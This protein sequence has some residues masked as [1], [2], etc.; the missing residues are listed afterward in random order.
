MTYAATT[1]PLPNRYLIILC[2]YRHHRSDHFVWIYTMTCPA[3]KTMVIFTGLC[4]DAVTRISLRWTRISTTSPPQE[5]QIHTMKCLEACHNSF[6]ATTEVSIASNQG[7][8]IYT[9]FRWHQYR[10]ESTQER[11]DTHHHNSA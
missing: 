4:K 8:W 11:P 6:E 9:R 1:S 10:W 3:T 2:L 7:T 5:P